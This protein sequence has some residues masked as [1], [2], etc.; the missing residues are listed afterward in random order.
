VPVRKI[1]LDFHNSE[2]IQSVGHGFDRGQFIDTLLRAHVDAIVVFAKDMHG[3][4]YYPSAFGP[5]HPGL[6]GRDLF[7]EQVDACREAGIKVFAYY[8]TTWDN[9]LAERHPEWLSLKR[10]RTSYLPRF[11]ETP[12]WTALCM[13]NQDFVDLMLAHTREIL[14]RYAIDGLWFDMPLTNHDQECYCRNC[15]TA[16]RAAGRDIFDRDAQGERTQLL[17]LD[18]MEA[19]SELASELRPGIV[20]DQNQQT[21]LGLHQR[22]EFLDNVDIEALPTAHWGYPYYPMMA[23]FVR[24][25]GI[26]FTGLTGRFQTEWADFGGLKSKNQLR[27]EVASIVAL[28]G[29]VSVGDQAPPSGSLDRAVY[30]TIGEAYEYLDDVEEYLS[31]AVPLAE[32]ALLVDGPMVTDFA[33]IES[34]IDPAVREGAL[35]MARL[36]TEHRVQFDVVEAGTVDLERYNVIFVPDGL[37]FREQTIAALEAFR[38][39]GGRIIHATTPQAS[40]ASMPWLRGL[41]IVDTEP[42]PFSPAYAVMTPRSRAQH[43]D[44]EFAL[45]DGAMRWRRASDADDSV[46][47]VL[48]EP[49]FQR[50]AEQFTSHGHSPVHV[51]TDYVVVA[52]NAEFGAFA[53]PVGTGYQR[54]GY[55]I[56]AEMFGEVLRTV[57]PDQIVRSDAPPS[58]ELALTYQPST[59]ESPPRVVVHAVNFTAAARRGGHLEYYDHVAP[60]HDVDVGLRLGVK[61]KRV[62]AARAAQELAFSDHDDEVR[63]SVPVV[64]QSELIVVELEDELIPAATVLDGAQA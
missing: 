44:F 23:R 57:F 62:R 5:V 10:D 53:F 42:S 31:G 18:W 37:P 22:A 25:L 41:G 43:S 52:A 1:H 61:V 59:S 47:A 64:H 2:H 8:C 49:R 24:A 36:L 34:Q 30:D 28:G 16:L 20:V 54:H 4:F 48:G 9:Y 14:E 50:S 15:V 13:S 39:R 21:R 7:G 58:V 29:G 32:A 56:Y 17:L 35:G 38:V 55:W 46:L 26:P 19:A 11:D 27:L 6:D 33:R 51:K 12:G 45:Y 60:I 3:Y 40:L 63:F